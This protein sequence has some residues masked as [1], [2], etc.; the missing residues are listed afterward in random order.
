MS[1][2]PTLR[3]G[4]LLAP[5]LLLTTVLIAATI[6]EIRND[7]TAPETIYCDHLRTEY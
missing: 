4:R 5:L 6:L 3:T 1:D 7:K 2:C